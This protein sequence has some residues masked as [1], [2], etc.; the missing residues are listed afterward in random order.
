MVTPA[1]SRFLPGFL[2]PRAG[3]DTGPLVLV[4]GPPRSGTTWLNR[5]ICTRP[6]WTAFLPECSFLTQQVGLYSQSKHYGEGRRF[7]AYFGDQPNLAAVYADTVVRMLDLTR[8]IN[9]F[10]ARDGM[11][12]KDP[13]LSH[14]VADLDDIM[15]AYQLVCIVRDPRD[16]LASAKKVAEKKQEA[17]TVDSA[18]SWIF[19]YFGSLL[20]HHQTKPRNAIFVRYED[21]V[22]GGI[23]P[24][25]SFLGQALKTTASKAD[26]TETVRSHLDPTDPFFSDLYLKS[27]TTEMIGSYAKVLSEPEIRRIEAI[28]SG[29][30]DRWNYAPWTGPAA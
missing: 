15:P 11:V 17:W 3:R 4:A 5:E 26:T 9:G 19:P 27:T 20:K 1:L 30:M 8:K 7:A 2:A 29:I 13:E 10:A 24:V 14:Y 12:L 18:S 21:M 16:V 25:R 28:F 22:S 6:G 23:D